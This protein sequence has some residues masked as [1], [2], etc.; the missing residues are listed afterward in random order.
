MKDCK[1]PQTTSYGSRESG[2]LC[3]SGGPPEAAHIS[4]SPELVGP[5]FGWVRVISPEK[6]WSKSWN[7]CYVLTVC[8][9]C[10][11]ERWQLLGNLQRGVSKGRQSCSRP[12][13]IPRWLDRRLTAAK[14]RCTNP[15][16]P[17]YPD[18]GGR[19][20]RFRFNSVV[21]AGKYM[22]SLPGYSREL[23]IDRIDTNGDYA[24]GNLRWVPRAQQMGNRRNTV[25]SEW[26]EKYWPYARS[27]VT[28]KLSSGMTREEI[29]A[30]AEL[31]VANRRKNWRGISER[32]RCMTYEMPD[33]I[34][35]TPYRESSSTTAATAG[36]STP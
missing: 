31:A 25:L 20:I 24:P 9:G 22:M 23:E 5:R 30:D 11:T 18:Y 7:H 6:R 29:I 13:A 27:V 1:L 28:R 15:N 33:E 26:D 34:T 17:G 14:Q 4:Y 36:E 2:N 12:R 21:E 16:D 10:G 19:G 3:G 8:E 32:L 35:A